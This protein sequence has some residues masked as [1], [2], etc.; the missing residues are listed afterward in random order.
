MTLL[1]AVRDSFGSILLGADGQEDR[2]DSIATFRDVGPT[3]KLAQ[4]ANRPV[5]WGWHGSDLIGDPFENWINGPAPDWTSWSTLATAANNELTRLHIEAGKQLG[6]LNPE[7]NTS[8][9]V[10]G[11]IAGDLQAKAFANRKIQSKGDPDTG[12]FVGV[13]SNCAW[14]GW[15]H[16]R[17]HSQPTAR[18]FYEWL[19]TLSKEAE[20][21]K[22][23]VQVW[24]LAPGDCR[25]LWFK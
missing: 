6:E 9:V 16:I 23:P 7:T 3:R 5:V 8:V 24:R 21:I 14:I 22:P 2:R 13:A 17:Q 12:L 10:G 1:A 25:E 20:G 4:V 18:N 19:Y 11:T 15:Q